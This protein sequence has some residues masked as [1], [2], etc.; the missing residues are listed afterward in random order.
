MQVSA[1]PVAPVSIPAAPTNLTATAGNAQASLSWSATSGAT[2]YKV[3]RST[4]NGSSYAAIATPTSTIYNDISVIN[5]MTYYYVVTAVN[6]A[7]ES[8]NSAQV[9]V[10][11]T[12]S[13]AVTGLHVSGNKI[14][15]GQNQ[16]L[17]LRGVNKQGTEYMCLYGAVFDGPS[18]AASVTVLRSWNINIVRL[19]INEQCWLG[20]NGLPIGGT[21]ANYRTAIIDYV[22]LL[23][24]GN[25]AVIIDLQWAAPGT[26]ISDKL[27]PMPDADHAPAFWTSVANTFKNN[28]S[29]ILDL[30]NEP[31]PDNNSNSTA[32]WICLRDGGNCPGV[33]Y[34]ANG[35]QIP[36]TAVGTQSLVNTIRATGS[37]NIIMV[38]GIQFANIMD[39]WLAYKPTDPLNQLAASWH[40][41]ATQ[42]CNNSTCWTSAIQ[43]ILAANIP[44]I[45]GEI[46]QNDCASTYINPLMTFLD[47]IGAHYL[48]WA[49]NAYPGD[50]NACANIP[51]LIVD[52]NGTPT[53]F[54][55]GFRNHLLGL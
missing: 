23:N 54:G 33:S 12:A 34:N 15:N 16:Q 55:L 11:P 42:A 6:S 28:S 30:F 52:F 5:G 18:D 43:P 50:A 51:A 32:A 1:T 21:A 29:I 17:A 40:S 35:T 41:Y 36:Y 38:A 47:T 53:A 2:S 22:N 24:T 46:G 13:I 20:I 39:Q 37:T 25:I 45:T 26:Y 10:A 8:T 7:G 48:A 9:T 44:L 4:V 19:P 49:W 27:T 31:W 3:K 14:L